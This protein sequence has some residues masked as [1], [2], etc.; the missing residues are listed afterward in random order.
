MTP[1]PNKTSLGLE[2]FCNEGDEVWT[3]PDAD[4]VELGSRELARIGLAKYADVEDGCVFR[5]PKSYPVYDADYR[6]HLDQIREYID[7]L[8]NFQTIGRNGLHRYNNQ[9]HSM[10]T[11]MLAVRNLVLGERNDLW[12]V[13]TDKEYHEEVRVVANTIRRSFQK[14][15][16]VALGGA[17]GLMVGVL[18]CLATLALVLRGGED[19]G[20]N[21]ALLS[22][23]FPG[24][25]VTA[26]GGIVGLAYGFVTGFVGGWLF[27]TLRN[28]SFFLSLM[29]LERGVQRRLLRQFFDYL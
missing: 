8:E 28:I 20:Q 10:L 14:M 4:L 16:S 21:L 19:I 24:Y 17:V 15:D 25:R 27:A 3:T 1:D 9:D 23:F 5:V 13:N 18:L 29:V 12:Q 7:S 26:V 22:Q 2:Y 6:D 11:G